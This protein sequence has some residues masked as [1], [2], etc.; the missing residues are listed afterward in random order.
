MPQESNKRP[1]RIPLT[2][3]EVKEFIRFKK[4]KERA[5]IERFKK[6]RTYKILNAFNVISIIIYTEIIFAFL[7]S[8]NFAPHYILSTTVY[9]GDEII[10][11]KRIF[12]SATFRMV[13]GK[14]YDVSIRDTVSLPNI[15]GKSY[16]PAKLYV[17]KDW[18]L[19][20]EIKVR[21]EM[22]EKDYFIKRSFPLLFISI[23]F[24]FVTF[25]LFGY[26]M[27]QHLYSIRVISFIN[28]VCLLSFILL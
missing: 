11:G 10:G 24:G 21:L 1:P 14:E 7:G 18:I 5:R 12:S 13:N 8:C 9:T 26:N 3:D 16:T 2:P 27:N 23:L 4:F 28:A 20:K 19:R 25:V 6:T 17:G 15:P 22:G